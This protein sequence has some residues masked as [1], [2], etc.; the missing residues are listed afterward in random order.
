MKAPRAERLKQAATEVIATKEKLSSVKALLDRKL[1]QCT[2]DQHK[3]QE[4]Y[5]LEQQV[6]SLKRSACEMKVARDYAISAQQRAEQSESNIRKKLKKVE[7]ELRD[8]KQVKEDPLTDDE[9]KH[10]GLSRRSVLDKN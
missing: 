5:D 3:Q 8:L 7:R 2:V 4:V 6:A 10:L 1:S 9:V